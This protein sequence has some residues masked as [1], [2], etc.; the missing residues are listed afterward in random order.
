MRIGL[1]TLLALVLCIA[2]AASVGMPRRSG[3][4]AC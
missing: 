1:H 2:G 3:C 4:T